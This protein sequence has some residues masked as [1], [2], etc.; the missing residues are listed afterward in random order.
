MLK[1]ERTSNKDDAG[2]KNE[3]DEWVAGERERE[4]ERE[5]EMAKESVNMSTYREMQLKEKAKR[6]STCRWAADST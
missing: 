5:R 6:P 3:W 2:H 4:R 1:K